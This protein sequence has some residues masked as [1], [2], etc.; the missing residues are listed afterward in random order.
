MALA[1][2]VRSFP[3]EKS[4]IS[5]EIASK[6]YWTLPY[7]IGKVISEL[8]LI[9]FMNGIFGTMVYHLTGLSR[10]AGKFRSFLSVMMLHGVVCQ[11][12]GLTIGAISPNSDV[13]LALFPAIMVLNI[14]FDGKNISVENTPR[15]LRWI[16]K[17][18]LVRWAFE[19]LCVNEFQDL[20]FDTSGPRRGP[21]A[22]TG[23]EALA[24]F[25]LGGFSVADAMRQQFQITVWCWALSYLGLTL[26]RQKFA[27]MKTQDE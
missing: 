23:A 27:V 14:I 11:S 26:T 13:A 5:N 1:A 19:A 8:P 25:G 6:M 20:T 22:K 3:R 9:G 17:V 12:A 24:R 16:P 10:S 4:I 18:G 7:F 21:V 15:L 2:A